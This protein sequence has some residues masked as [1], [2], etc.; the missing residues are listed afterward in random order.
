M[1]NE[2]GVGG[3]DRSVTVHIRRRRVQCT[4][5]NQLG[6]VLQRQHRIRGVDGTVIIYIAEGD[7]GGGDGVAVPAALLHQAGIIYECHIHVHVADHAVHASVRGILPQAVAAVVDVRLTALRPVRPPDLAL[8]HQR[9]QIEHRLK[10]DLVGIY[11]RAPARPVHAIDKG[12]AQRRARRVIGQC[13]VVVPLNVKI[14]GVFQPLAVEPREQQ[15]GFRNGCLR[16]G[17]GGAVIG[18]DIQTGG[19]SGSVI[20]FKI[21]VFPHSA[22]GAQDHEIHPRRFDARPVDGALIGGN[23]D[24]AGENGD[25]GGVVS[26]KGGIVRTL[27]VYGQKKHRN[28]KRNEQQNAESTARGGGKIHDGFLSAQSALGSWNEREKKTQISGTGGVPVPD[29][30]LREDYSPFGPAS[31]MCCGMWVYFLKF[32]LNFFARSFAL[33]S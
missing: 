1:Q 30:E 5:V 28:T 24:A 31:T 15:L 21:L 26:F 12:G 7:E 14:D 19:V 2:H 29:T 13:A 3:I 20:C 22:A 9:G 18:A 16:C 23:I 4:A 11:A 17:G 33:L 6:G 27:A 8:L 25:K 32:S 10:P